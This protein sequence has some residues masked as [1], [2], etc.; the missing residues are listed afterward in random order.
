MR[1]INQ[2]KPNQLNIWFY[3]DG[4]C[5]GERRQQMYDSLFSTRGFNRSR[6]IYLVSNT[7]EQEPILTERGIEVVRWDDTIYDLMPNGD[8]WRP[9]YNQASARD[10]CDLLRFLFLRGWAGSYIDTDDMCIRPIP[11]PSLHL[12]NKQSNLNANMVCRSYD[13]HTC[14]YDGNTREMCLPGNLRRQKPQYDHIQIFPRTDV[15][16][17]HQENSPIVRHLLNRPEMDPDRG[18]NTIYSYGDSE[19]VSWQTMIMRTCHDMLPQHRKTWN[20]EMTLIYLYESHVANCSHWDQGLHGGE[21]HQIWPDT[22]LLEP[23]GSQRFTRQQ[24]MTFKKQALNQFP[25]ATHLWLH[26]KGDSISPEWNARYSTNNN[27]HNL[28]STYWIE[29]IRKDFNIPH[30]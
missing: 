8:R 20:L 27:R 5:E 24:F 22:Q 26:D 18:I 25:K 16:L 7:W 23:W 14:H 12:N 11:M 30:V 17:N 10:R 29:Q 3:W 21:M 1:L 9:L 4:P 15:W 13:P 19:V 6:P 2:V 28:L